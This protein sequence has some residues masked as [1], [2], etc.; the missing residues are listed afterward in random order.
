MTDRKELKRTAKD[1]IR[2]ARPRAAVVTLIFLLVLAAMVFFDQRIM[3]K[4]VDWSAMESEMGEISSQVETWEDFEAYY[5]ELSGRL[6]ETRGQL[7]P[8]G[9]LLSMSLEILLVIWLAGFPLYSLRVWRQGTADT[10]ALFDVFG[11][12]FRVYF[13]DFLQRLLLSIG[14]MLLLVPGIIL[15]YALRQSRF[16]LFDHPEWT[17]GRC[18]LESA[19]LMRGHKWKLFMLD[20]SFAGWAILSLIPFAALYT[21]PMISFAQAGFY[22][23]LVSAPDGADEYKA[24]TDGEKPP[25]EY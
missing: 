11:L 10:G 25:W 15:S 2:T 21:L 1:R 13:L 19:R 24:P 20:L 16:L 14:Y 5:N 6:N 17:A 4:S 23:G 3:M 8:M 12:F 7:D 18:M 22:D 9:K